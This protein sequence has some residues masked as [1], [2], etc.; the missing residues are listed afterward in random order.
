MDDI[1]L[2]IEQWSK[3]RPDLNTQPM[4]LI[5]RLSRTALLMS[6]KMDK[7][8]AQYHLNQ[9]SFDVLATL[10]RS[11]PPHALSPN[12]LLGTMMITS[13]TMTNRIDRLEEA[14][15]VERVQSKTDKRSVLI[16]LTARGKE[17]IN[18]T[19]TAHVKTQKKLVSKLTDEEQHLLN[20]LL[21]KYLSVKDTA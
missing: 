11:G 5:G 7:T 15:L 9:P 2:I 21:K 14:G 4:A 18:E 16:A 12:D 13:G 6:Q 8:F 17:L 1:D 19:V 10:L 20:Q 3:Q